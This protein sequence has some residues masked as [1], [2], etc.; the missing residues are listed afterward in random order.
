MHYGMENW[1]A[2]DHC[3]DSILHMITNHAVCLHPRYLN[4]GHIYDRNA[5]LLVER[6]INAFKYILEHNKVVGVAVAMA[7]STNLYNT[8]TF[9]KVAKLSDSHISQSYWK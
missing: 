1:F 4:F 9:K 8:Q 2:E 5:N 3:L 7:I 6:N